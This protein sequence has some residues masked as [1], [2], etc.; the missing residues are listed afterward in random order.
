MSSE[1]LLPALERWVLRAPEEPWLIFRGERGHYRWWSFS[2][3][4]GAVREGTPP[5]SLGEELPIT[6]L[7]R[8]RVVDQR[9]PMA[10]PPRSDRSRDVWLAQDL[11]ETDVSRAL[12]H[13]ALETGCAVLLE[14]GPIHP[15]LLL[16]ARPTV[17]G[18]FASELGALFVQVGA[19]APR[20]GRHRYLLRR[21]RRL[22]LLVATG[23]WSE[24]VELQEHLRTL[25]LPRELLVLPFP[26]LGVLESAE[27]EEEVPE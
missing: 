19:V 14:P 21:L 22:R 9:C 15:E 4:L 10:I 25:P 3:A 27:G 12:A 7:N 17:L 23:T 8:L 24:Q 13:W 6:F 18:G 26:A 5:R 1:E 20:W 11:L 2:R 16:W